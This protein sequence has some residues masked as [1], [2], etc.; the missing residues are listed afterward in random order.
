[1]FIPNF[2]PDKSYLK[3][4]TFPWKCQKM[5]LKITIY[6]RGMFP[7]HAQDLV[8]DYFTKNNFVWNMLHKFSFWRDL[9]PKTDFRGGEAFLTEETAHKLISP[10]HLIFLPPITPTLRNLPDSPP[11][12]PYS[13]H[14]PLQVI[15]TLMWRMSPCVESRRTAR[16]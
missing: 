12:W 1:M 16:N 15:P 8:K 4:S 3:N 6:F 2:Y 7:A 11:N 13:D 10:I 9:M 14:P 5:N